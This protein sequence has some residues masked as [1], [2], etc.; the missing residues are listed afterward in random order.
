MIRLCFVIAN[1]LLSFRLMNG[2]KNRIV[3]NS[4]EQ[5]TDDIKFFIIGNS[6]SQGTDY[7]NEDYSIRL[8]GMINSIINYALSR[9]PA[10]MLSL[11]NFERNQ[12]ETF[13]STCQSLNIPA[14]DVKG[15]IA[16]DVVSNREEVEQH[17]QINNKFCSSEFWSSSNTNSI[18]LQIIF[19]DS[20]QKGI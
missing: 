2:A 6:M 8:H 7:N 15:R 19:I 5:Q 14:Y 9:K 1:I 18:M 13:Y 10:F 20:S 16:Y 12:R 11:G 3:L 17:V 4:I